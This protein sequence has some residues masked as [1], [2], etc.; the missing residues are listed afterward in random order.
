MNNNTAVVR[1]SVVGKVLEVARVCVDTERKGWRVKMR[2]F[3]D[4]MDGLNLGTSEV[5]EAFAYLEARLQLITFLDADGQVTGIS[6]VP[7]WYQRRFCKMWL[8]MRAERE[9]YIDGCCASLKIG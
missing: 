9:H 5:R 3:D 4:A 1:K 7:L 8:Y 2:E 6:V